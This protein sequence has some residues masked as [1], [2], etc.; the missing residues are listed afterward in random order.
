MTIDVFMMPFCIVLGKIAC[1]APARMGL[2][3]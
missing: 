2:T 1:S 3:V